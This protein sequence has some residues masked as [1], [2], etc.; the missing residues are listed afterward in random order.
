[1]AGETVGMGGMN[2]VGGSWR[3]NEMNLRIHGLSRSR[4][5]G[6]T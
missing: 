4:D 1:M 5:T 6:C 2:A 3:S